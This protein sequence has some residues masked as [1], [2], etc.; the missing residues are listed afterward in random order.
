[1]QAAWTAVKR[2]HEVVLY[3]MT[4]RLGGML[5]IGSKL[6]FKGDLEEV[7]GMADRP[8][9]QAKGNDQV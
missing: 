4:D 6:P 7:S 9:R 3:E 8:H 2:G 1:M 5:D